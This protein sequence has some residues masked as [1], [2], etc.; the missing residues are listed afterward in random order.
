MEP[1][2]IWSEKQVHNDII[3][4][5]YLQNNIICWLL[6]SNQSFYRQIAGYQR[7]VGDR[8][9]G[10]WWKGDMGNKIVARP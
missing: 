6:P 10:Q 9:V 5:L 3:M 8:R 4:L 7:G 2:S 1:Q